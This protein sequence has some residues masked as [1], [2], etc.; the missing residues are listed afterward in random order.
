MAKPYYKKSK[1]HKKNVK[2]GYK[3]TTK[4]GKKVRTERGTTG[5]AFKN[6][7]SSSRNKI[8]E[9]T[10]TEGKS[11]VA[12]PRSGLEEYSGKV[13][14]VKGGYAKTQDKNKA[15]SFPNVK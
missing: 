5:G 1:W 2:G 6:Q 3:M 10:S 15:L 14:K 8:T 13:V 4:S 12:S 7:G 9:S 11:L